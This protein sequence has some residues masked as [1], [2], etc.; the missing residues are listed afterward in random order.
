MLSP[1]AQTRW[2]RCSARA[3]TL[4]ALRY[5]SE[6]QQSADHHHSQNRPDSIAY[7]TGQLPYI[8]RAWA[9]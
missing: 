4:Y 8:A 9:E 6:E 5:V 1:I 3:W 2:W 7:R